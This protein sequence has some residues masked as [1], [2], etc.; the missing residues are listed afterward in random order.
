MDHL[1]ASNIGLRLG[2]PIFRGQL[3][4]I[5]LEERVAQNGRMP[6]IVNEQSGVL[7]KNMDV[8]WMDNF[9]LDTTRP[10][11][12]RYLNYSMSKGYANF[13]HEMLMHFRNYATI[14]EA[15]EILL[16]TS[17][18]QIGQVFL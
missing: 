3:R 11:V 4:S 12:E 9:M 2:D 10:S 13:K 5:R 6:I 8:I 14:E 16:G 7:V 18:L 17:H 15:V 1:A